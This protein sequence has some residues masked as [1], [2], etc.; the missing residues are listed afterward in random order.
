MAPRVSRGAQ[1]VLTGLSQ[2][3]A[4]GAADDSMVGN[5]LAKRSADALGPPI[6]TRRR[7]IF[8]RAT[9]EESAALS[10]LLEQSDDRMAQIF[11]ASDWLPH[12]TALF[13]TMSAAMLTV[14]EPERLAVL[15]APS[16]GY[17][18]S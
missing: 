10:A 1:V 2:D 18:G 12:G 17:P 16:D 9:T 15:L 14:I 11:M 8:E 3:A 5:I 6:Y 7:D 4:R 13:L